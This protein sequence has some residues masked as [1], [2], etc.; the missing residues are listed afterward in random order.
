MLNAEFLAS[1]ALETDH[2]EA[3]YLRRS[4]KAAA[5]FRARVKVAVEA[6]CSKPLSAGFLVGKRARKIMLKPTSVR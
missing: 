5:G 2:A 3:W 4:A 1:A 6:A